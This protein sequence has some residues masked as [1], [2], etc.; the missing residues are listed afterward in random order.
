M[1]SL[2]NVIIGASG[3]L[4]TALSER[5]TASGTV[6]T[7]TF[8]HNPVPGLTRL[9]ITDR[10]GVRTFFAENKPRTA[11]L[12]ACLTNV[13]YCE[14]NRDKAR[15]VN[16]AG[17]KNVADACK[18]QGTRLVFISTYYVFDGRKKTYTESDQ[19]HAINFYGKTKIDG[20]RITAALPGSLIIRACKIYS[21]GEDDRN[22]A[23]RTLAALKKGETVKVARDQVNNPIEAGMLADIILSLIGK[24]ATGLYHAG[25]TENISNYDFALLLAETSG[26]DT[27]LI[28]PVD[29]SSLKQAA[30]RPLHCCLDISRLRSSIKIKIP[31]IAES[32]KVNK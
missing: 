19:T 15:R 9:D 32:L 22:F 16:V 24:G 30:K 20:E 29:T 12:A 2:D 10:E 4:G 25:G 8:S 23:V 31:T 18:E 21:K 27:G 3:Q 6:V 5:L 1:I 17:T 7:G 13:D 14:L 11:I 28:V 26:M